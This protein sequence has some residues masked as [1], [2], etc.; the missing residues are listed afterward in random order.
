M[1]RAVV[2]DA[3]ELVRAILR[4]VLSRAGI[5]V[6]GDTGST[7]HL[8]ELCRRCAPDVVV[9]GIVLG[10]EPLEP[11]LAKVLAT[12]T[13][14]LVLADS[15]APERLGG[16]LLA[17]ASGYL[18]LEDTA[19]ARVAEAV[20]AVGRGE[21]ALHPMAAGMVLEQWRRLRATAGNQAPKDVSL[22][23]REREVLAAMADGLATKSIARQLGVAAKT[24]D[25]HKARIFAKLRARNQSEAVS[26][27]IA[28]GLLLHQAGAGPTNDR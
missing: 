17:G 11:S 4:A 2:A 5:D 23:P 18:A 1:V 6:V 26:V 19:P 10:G 27:A 24:V 14:V 3:S 9:A 20:H 15:A 12:G 16:V 7:T 28:A 13:K 25:N 8:I 22:T 21:A